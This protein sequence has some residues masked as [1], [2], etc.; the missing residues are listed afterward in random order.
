[1]PATIDVKLELL[2]WAV[3][4]SGLPAEQFGATYEKWLSGERKPTYAQLE[5][6]ARRA[7]VPMGYL[8]L[9]K[10]PVEELPLPDFRTRSDEGVRQPTP[11]L[12]ETIYEMQQRQ[13]W[14]REYL[15]D[16]GNEAL[17]YVGSATIGEAIANVT[18]NIRDA[19][20]L[21]ENWAENT[22]NWED[23][24][25][26]LTHRT[27][28]AGILIFANGIV[29]NNTHRPLNAEEFQGF[30]FVDK[31]V[32]LIFVNNADF[33][34]AQMFTVAHE[35]AHVWVGQSALFDLVATDPADI[36]VEKY[37]NA[38][39]AEF[40]VPAE[41]LQASWTRGDHA[42]IIQ[43]LARRFKVSAIVVA[44]RAKDIGII[45]AQQ[46]F[47]FY[48]A[49]MRA[50]H[51]RAESREKGGNFWNTQR[52]RLGR[53]FV[54]AVITATHEGRLSYSGAYELTRLYGK[55]FDTYA[56]IVMK[57]DSE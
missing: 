34:V 40:L 9:E 2:R 14:M 46:F 44:R 20:S 10:P 25:R 18:A 7:M 53:R 1:M 4:R 51:V 38:V 43:D 45:T 48:K 37:C 3:G 16:R 15:A 11:N 29:G 13:E 57:E 19:L 39:A 32:P 47:A 17:P 24:L 55:S 28:S 23:A 54:R 35:L 52:S 5:D 50:E 21:S 27:E 6:F 30:V 12:L 42:L 33:K 56:E 26:L 31:I 22:Q 36:E 8:F 41:K 49:H